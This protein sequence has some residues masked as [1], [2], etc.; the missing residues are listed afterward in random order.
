MDLSDVAEFRRNMA[1]MQEEDPES[2]EMEQYLKII[3]ALQQ[4]SRTYRQAKAEEVWCINW[5]EME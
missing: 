3:S 4:N 1:D 5:F 2:I